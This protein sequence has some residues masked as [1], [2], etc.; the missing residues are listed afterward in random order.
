MMIFFKG[1]EHNLFTGLEEEMYHGSFGRLCY[2]FWSIVM[3]VDHVDFR[4]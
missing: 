3:S 2:G 1:C 4:E